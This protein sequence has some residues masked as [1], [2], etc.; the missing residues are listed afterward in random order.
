MKTPASMWNPSP[1]RY[2]PQP[3]RWEYPSGAWVLKVDSQEKVKVKGRNWKISKALAGGRARSGKNVSQMY[4]ARKGV[5]TQEVE[6]VA[7]RE[8]YRS[9][10]HFS[11]I[12]GAPE[13]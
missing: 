11:G 1:R 2:N 7:L 8:S 12:L 5:V 13:Q 3:P 10:A 6:F 4:Y 9:P